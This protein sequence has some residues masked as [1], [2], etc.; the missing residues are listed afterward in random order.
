[1]AVL[2]A[3]MQT[4]LAVS[5]LLCDCDPEALKLFD[6]RFKICPSLMSVKKVV[7]TSVE[8]QRVCVWRCFVGLDINLQ[9]K[10]RSY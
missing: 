8:N 4:I 9:L 1:M 6:F 3:I 5:L 2:N 7:A 10:T